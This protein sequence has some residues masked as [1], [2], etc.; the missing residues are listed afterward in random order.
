MG[1]APGGPPMPGPP[2]M[3]AYPPLPHRVS[4]GPGGPQQ[5]SPMWPGQPM[6][7]GP[8]PQGPW[9]QQYPPG[10]GSF[11]PQPTEVRQAHRASE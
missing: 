8:P 5:G 4:D 1:G 11:P 9:G 3:S 10:M 6:M 7:M 2:G